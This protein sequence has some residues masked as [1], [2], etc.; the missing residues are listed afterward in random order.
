MVQNLLSV[1]NET[2]NDPD[3]RD[4][5]LFYWRLLA[6][7]LELAKE[8][9]LAPKPAIVTP[10]VDHIDA[11]LADLLE[12]KI[13]KISSVLMEK[14]S[15]FVTYKNLYATPKEFKDTGMLEDAGPGAAAAAKQSAGT[16]APENDALPAPQP[17][18]DLI[19]DLLSLDVPVPT[20][21]AAPA[22][23]VVDPWSGFGQQSSNPF[24]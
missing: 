10:L 13:P 21:Q 12:R 17:Q 18:M 24:D 5:A 8:V 9:I 4:R 7:D 2:V 19:G 22:P 14:P 16:A 1:A 3:V 11:A 15:A 23:P 6:G 20:Q